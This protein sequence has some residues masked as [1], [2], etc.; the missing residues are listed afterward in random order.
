[1]FYLKLKFGPDWED[2]SIIRNFIISILSQKITSYE[3][4]YRVALVASELMENACRYSTS[5]GACLELEQG[6]SNTTQLEFRIRNITKEEN[7][8]EFKKI[9]ELINNGSA[10]EAYKKMMMRIINN[11]G[12]T[13]SQLG[14]ARIRYE[15]RSEISYEIESDIKPLLLGRE[16]MYNHKQ[17][18]LCV[19]STMSITPKEIGENHGI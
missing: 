17:L 1:V 6:I 19:K 16:N 14:L 5:G 15:G 4:A 8:K 13:V 9:F 18:I 11:D 7:I 2:I 10:G 12:S 3:E